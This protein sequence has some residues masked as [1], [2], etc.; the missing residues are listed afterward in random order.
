MYRMLV[1]VAGA[2]LFTLYHLNGPSM[3]PDGELDGTLF[4][5]LC[6]HECTLN[7]E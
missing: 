6:Q 4:C 7:H 5:D 2:A 3:G 1:L